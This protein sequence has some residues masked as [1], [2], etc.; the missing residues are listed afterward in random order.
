MIK[1]IIFDLDGT[2]LNT[3]SDIAK[4]MNAVLE[5]YGYQEFTEDEYMLKVGNGFRKLI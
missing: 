5:D 3:I 2:L 4:S 1:G